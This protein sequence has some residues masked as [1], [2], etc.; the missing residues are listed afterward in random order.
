MT[1]NGQYVEVLSDP[2]S[3]LLEALRD[4]LQLTGTKKG[5]GSGDCGACTVNVDGKAV[6]SCIYLV[7]QA[8]GKNVLTVEG[9]ASDNGLHHLQRAFIKN[10]AV[11]CG[12]CIPGML[13][14]A[15]ALLDEKSDPSDEDIRE[16][17]GGNLCRCT[18]Y[19]R[20]VKAV[21][22]AAA[23]IAQHPRRFS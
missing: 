18:G 10:G 21:R 13:M 11:Q 8:N 14:S 22:G 20:I 9:L 15:K 3:S 4:Q 2:G 19:V 5:C 23:E 1:V 7:A 17:L 12:Y 6:C 16:Y